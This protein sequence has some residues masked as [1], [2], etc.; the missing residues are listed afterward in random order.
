M[1]VT[2]PGKKLLKGGATVKVKL[3]IKII[4]PTGKAQTVTKTI[5]VRTQ[6]EVG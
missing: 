2:A 1:K 4:R 5:R 6:P 3:S